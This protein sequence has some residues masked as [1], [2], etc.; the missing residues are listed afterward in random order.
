M[1]KPARY[2]IFAIVTL[3][4]IFAVSIGNPA[5]GQQINWDAG[6]VGARLSSVN[7]DDAR[8]D[9]PLGLGVFGEAP[10]L[11]QIKVGASLDYWRTTDRLTESFR[12]Q[13][14]ALG[15]YGK[16]FMLPMQADFTSY[17]LGGFGL[18]NVRA[19]DE[20]RSERAT[21]LGVDFGAGME[22]RIDQFLSFNG[23]VRLRNLNRQGH[24]DYSMGMLAK[25]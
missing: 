11:P 19:D 23:E 10:L 1:D 12:A 20:L 17:V 15:A 22:A 6:R 18:H 7:I 2:V 5:F 24:T 13:N 21:K 25:F 14:F 3:M 9:D 8:Y 4:T 16:Y